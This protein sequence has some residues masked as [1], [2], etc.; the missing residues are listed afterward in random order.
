VT[1]KS[2]FK[3]Y[4]VLTEAFEKKEMLKVF[5]KGMMFLEEQ[6]TKGK[7]SL[8]VED[9]QLFLQFSSILTTKLK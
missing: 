8:N 4:E 9:N 3:D 7:V 1:G 5:I 2:T 6:R